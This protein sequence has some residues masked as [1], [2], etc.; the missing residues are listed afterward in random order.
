M[1]IVSII[2]LID[3][4]SLFSHDFEFLST[5]LIRILLAFV[6]L[7]A[8]L[9]HFIK[10]LDTEKLTRIF[11][12]SNL[13][14]PPLF[15]L[16]QIISD[17][18]FYGILRTDLFGTKSIPAILNL[19]IGVILFILTLKFSKISKE[20]KR[21]ETIAIVLYLGFFLFVIACLKLFSY[22]ISTSIAFKII[23]KIIIAISLIYIGYK[24][25]KNTE[26]LFKPVLISILLIFIY[27]L[28]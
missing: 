4:I 6:S 25:R 14:F 10:Q 3:N 7:T 5:I 21:Q 19:I 23:F 12:L 17:Y 11:I 1:L 13:I 16:N 2:S 26:K 8:V 22:D 9:S 28:F 24:F 18:F 20:N 15:I 27:N